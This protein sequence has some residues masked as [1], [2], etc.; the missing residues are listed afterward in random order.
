M[1]TEPIISGESGV[2]AVRDHLVGARW[3]SRLG[4]E[5]AAMLDEPHTI[6]GVRLHRA[7]LKPGRKLSGWYTV[8]AAGA[9][10]RCR[11]REV[12]V[13]WTPVGE[14]GAEAERHEQSGVERSVA[15]PFRMLER[16]LPHWGMHI[17][18]FP[19]DR[20]FPGLTRLADPSS[21]SALLPAGSVP[22]SDVV[23]IR[24]RPGERHVLRYTSAVEA[25]ARSLFA[26]LHR[27]AEAASGRAT[28]VADWLARDGGHVAAVR[29]VRLLAAEQAA[30]YPGVDGR[31]LRPVRAE[32]RQAGMALRALHAAPAG[33]AGAPPHQFDGELAAVE[34][35][36]AHVGVLLPEAGPVISAV[37]REARAVYRRL[38]G[39]EHTLVHGDAKIDH[40]WCSTRGLTLLDLDRVCP[41]D[42]AFDI[43]KLLADV[44]WRFAIAGGPGAAAAQRGLLDGYGGG[45]PA[46]VERARIYEVVLLLKIAGRRVPLFDP[47]WADATLGLVAASRAALAQATGQPVQRRVSTPRIPAG[48]SR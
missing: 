5:L 1:T 19:L 41:G 38:P 45:S 18:V 3:Q 24:Y 23:A 21:I 4:R 35:A 36:C 46:R 40:F 30:I 16:R 11:R 13:T 7:K 34:R 37:L 29:P 14:D 28:A 22:L 44:H 26:K 33:L 2:E 6:A 43:G 48:A 25:G 15:V 31:P 47:R 27:D 12:A 8:D 10:G 42:P 32:L 9:D 17:R 20:D 39:E